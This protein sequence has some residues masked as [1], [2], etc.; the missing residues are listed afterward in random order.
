MDLLTPNRLLLGRNNERSPVGDFIVTDDP[1][2]IL[3][4]NTK[5]YDSWFETWL[6]SHVP[7][8][9]HQS[10]WFRQDRNLQIGDIVLFTKVNSVISKTY[11]YGM[12]KSIETGDDGNVRRVVVEYK[13]PNENVKRETSRSVR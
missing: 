2:K 5:I 6:L 4:M 8:L 10:K 11:T 7:K 1:S 12:I 9:M 3:K 13:N